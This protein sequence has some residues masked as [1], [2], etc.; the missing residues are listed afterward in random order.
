MSEFNREMALDGAYPVD[1]Y[2]EM[3]GYIADFR[4]GNRTAKSSGM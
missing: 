1:L 4:N 2:D 3:L